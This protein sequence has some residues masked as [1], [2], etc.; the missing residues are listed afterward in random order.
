MLWLLYETSL[1]KDN[2]TV[3]HALK[4]TSI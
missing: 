3:K 2:I 1:H 4:G